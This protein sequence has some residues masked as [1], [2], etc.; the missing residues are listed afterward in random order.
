MLIGVSAVDLILGVLVC[1][2]YNWSDRN[3]F[4]AI[5]KILG[6][7]LIR[8]LIKP[9]GMHLCQLDQFRWNPIWFEN[10]IRLALK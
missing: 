4:D 1:K 10:S 8:F 2:A 6:S 9:N 7:D 3:Q 5:K